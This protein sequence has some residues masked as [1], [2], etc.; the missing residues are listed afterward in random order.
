MLGPVRF[1]H[2]KNCAKDAIEQYREEGEKKAKRV[3]VEEDESRRQEL[4]RVLPERDRSISVLRNLLAERKQHEGSQK[5]E[6]GGLV[7][8]PEYAKLPL[9]TLG[10]LE[11]ARDA[12]IGWILKEI[13][14]AEA[15]QE[16][17]S[18]DLK[19]EVDGTS[20]I[21]DYAQEEL[22]KNWAP[23]V[24]DPAMNHDIEGNKGDGAIE[25]LKVT[26]SPQQPGI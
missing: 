18:R 10:S 20:E 7:K 13:E 19:P 9:P 22:S 24:E 6:S 12:T 2:I 21:H 11:R 4:I 23:A 16:Q 25:A 8:V 1:E 3:K 14:K 15:V 26:K 5:A 17:I